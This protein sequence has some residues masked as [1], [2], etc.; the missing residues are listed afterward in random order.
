MF[1]GFEWDPS[2]G[3]REKVKEGPLDDVMRERS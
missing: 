1:H 3:V 2:Q